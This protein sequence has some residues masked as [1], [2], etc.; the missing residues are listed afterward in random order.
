MRVAGHDFMDY[1]PDSSVE[2]RGGS[3]GCTAYSDPDNAGLYE[4]LEE[5]LIPQLY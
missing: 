3:D 4:C 2:E 1:R 5:Y